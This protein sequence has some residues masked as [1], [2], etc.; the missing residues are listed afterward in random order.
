[1]KVLALSA[2]DRIGGA[3]IGAYRLHQALARAGVDSQMLTLRKATADPA[4]QRLSDHLGRG[5]RARRRLA[6]TRH[7]RRLRANPRAEQAGHW[8]LNQFDYPLAAAINSFDADIVHLHWVGDNFLPIEQLR[9]I[10]APII[11]T[12]R[13]MWAFSGG[14]HYA[15]ACRR[16]RGGCGDC[17]QLASASGNDI[18]ARVHRQKQRAWAGLDLTLVC[19]SDW[20]AACAR[21]SSLFA[22]KRV[23]VIGNPIDAAVFKPLDRAAA[24]RAFNLPQDKKLILFGAVGGTSD[25]RKGF[26]YLRRAL[27]RRQRGKDWELVIFGGERELPLQLRLP[28]HQLGRLR[29]EVSLSLLYAACDVYVLPTLQ[30]ALG[31]TLIEAL[32]CGSPCVAFAGSGASDVVRHQRDGYL[33]RHQDSADL[34]AGIGWVL[35]QNWSRAALHGAVCARFG[36]ERIAER[37]IAV[38]RSLLQAEADA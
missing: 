15:G 5:G 18:S 35:A 31:N 1:M 20:L 14:C 7:S 4:V 37:Y 17:P 16:Y 26:E 23:E 12:L 29:D 13:D 36:Q 30:E 33:A 32:A 21:A 6:E 2:N 8:S 3:A 38:Y 9:H 22:E 11:W 27:N 25:R 19:I 10:R 28:T 24:R 34:A